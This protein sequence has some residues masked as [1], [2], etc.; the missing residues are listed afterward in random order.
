MDNTEKLKIKAQKFYKEHNGYME[1]GRV[2]LSVLCDSTM[3]FLCEMV[4][5]LE[6]IGCTDIQTEG[7]LENDGLYGYRYKANGKIPG[8]DCNDRN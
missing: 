8:G 1:N 3:F 4:E 6:M 2:Y 7:Y 5:F